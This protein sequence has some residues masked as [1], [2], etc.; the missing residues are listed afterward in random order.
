MRRLSSVERGT[1]VFHRVGEA[2]SSACA[3]IAL[4]ERRK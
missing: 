2:S 3:A 1:Q 4:W